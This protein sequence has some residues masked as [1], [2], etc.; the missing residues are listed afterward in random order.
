LNGS[1]LDLCLEVPDG[2]GP[3]DSGKGTGKVDNS[4]Q[5]AVLKR[6]M[7][8][9]PKTFHVIETR[10]WK[11][12]KVPIIILGYASNSGEE[13]ETDIS[14]GVDFEGV[15]KGLTDRIVRRVLARVPRAMHAA[16]L[17]KLWARQEKLN[18]AYDG[19]LNSLGWTLLVLFFFMERGE[20][21]TDMLEDEEP[22]ENGED[23]QGS[24]PPPLHPSDNYGQE[25][26]R[27]LDVPTSDEMADFFSWVP[28]Y[29]ST[30][31]EDVPGS[32][33]GIS[34]VD[35]TLIEVPPPDKKW[36]D[37][38]SFY[39]EDPGPRVTK[40]KSENVARS[41]KVAPWRMTLER[42]RATAD[43][44][45]THPGAA[46]AWAARLVRENAEELVRK[47]AEQKAKKAGGPAK[48]MSKGGPGGQW[49]ARAAPAQPQ[50]RAWP[51]QPQPPAA[52]PP[53]RARTGEICR[54]F[55]EGNCWDGDRC[56]LRHY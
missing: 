17:V 31:P 1:D 50:K 44:L 28:E 41:L 10:F 40:G 55:L 22:N 35:G 13:V 34:L 53:K 37:Q 32:N 49:A 43:T 46:D 29:C 2:N 39:I 51:G 19:Y 20:V 11:H 52:P 45:C 33:W 4:K 27:L 54:W 36:N 14:V 25:E 18:K 16:R 3:E 26:D 6:I 47:A 9:L 48:G 8:R 7:Y 12:M 21:T 23:G 42:C 24:L 15:R 38:P 30:W 5:V 56:R